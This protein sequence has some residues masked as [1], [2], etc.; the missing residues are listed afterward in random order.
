MLMPESMHMSTNTPAP[1]LRDSRPQCTICAC[2]I[3]L[4]LGRQ[5]LTA[6]EFAH[7]FEIEKE[8]GV[9]EANAAMRRGD[10]VNT[11]EHRA[12]LHT[13]LRDPQLSAP[14]HK[15]VAET[16]ERMCEL[17]AEVRSG[18]RT[19]CRGDMITDVINVGI[20]GSELGP[21]AVYHALRNPVPT[22]RLHFL[23]AADGVN[24]DRVVSGL[25]PFKTLVI[26]SSKSFKT[27]ETAVN[28]T[29]VDQWL[30][31]AGI[32]GKDRNKH[33]FV[34]STNRNAAREMNLPDENL[35]PIW[36]WVGGRFSVW[37]AIGLADAIALGPE[38]FRGL[39]AGAHSMDRHVAS[40]S[41]EENLPLV[42]A[43]LAYWNAT[44]NSM[45]SHAM[46]PYDE[47]L[48]V[49]VDWLQ[50]LEMESLGK[51]LSVD[52][53]LIETPTG[54][55]VWGGHGNVSQ[56]SFYQWLREGTSN[57]SIDL[58]WCE[59]PGHKHAE[60]HRVLNANAKAQVEA[61]VTRRV[62]EDKAFN[63]VTAIAIEQLTP[64]TLGAL[65]AMYEHKTSMLGTLYG[66]NPFDQPG[67]ELGKKLSRQ[68][69]KNL[70]C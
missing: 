28:A 70:G 64:E 59:K 58:L 44:R 46:L 31:D 26:V 36:D 38:V 24:F 20:G 41:P 15:E 37:S 5:R 48:R 8:K 51:N 67:V 25:N 50:Q 56:H 65:M 53:E 27:R 35:F 18:L 66:V 12:A 61:L 23:A 33:M 1:F 7:L 2:G 47:R 17:A 6:E 57:T 10:I 30:L 9:L 3:A 54:Q 29:A 69:E 21:R 62:P 45:A 39:L 68:A 13:A 55:C 49:I 19:G 40:A 4:D 63:A 11:S 32:T 52:G 22:I 34:V 14:C 43:L 16:L 60:L 42:L